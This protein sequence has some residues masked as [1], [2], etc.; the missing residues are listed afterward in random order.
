MKEQNIDFDQVYDI[1]ASGL[2]STPLKSAMT[3]WAIIHSLWKPIPG[4]FKDYIGLPKENMYQS[5]HTSVIGLM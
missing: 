1:T 3:C 2:L 5:L 4:K